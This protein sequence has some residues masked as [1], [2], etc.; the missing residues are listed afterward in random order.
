MPFCSFVTLKLI[1]KP[2]GILAKRISKNLRLMNRKKR[3]YTFDLN[4]KIATYKKINS[5]AA[6]E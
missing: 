6:V 4:D 3:F 2:I 1:S 5:I